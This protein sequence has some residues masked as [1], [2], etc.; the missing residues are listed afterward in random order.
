MLEKIRENIYKVNIRFSSS[1]MQEVNCYLFKGEQGYTVIDT[2]LYSKEA[3]EVWRRVLETGIVVEKVV[4]THTHQD[5]IGL[6][7]WFQDNVGVPVYT[8]NLGYKEMQKNRETNVR[9]KIKR[10]VVKHGGYELPTNSEDGSFIY[11]F[12]PDGFFEKNREI[13]LGD[14]LYEAIW[15]PGHAP[16]HFCFYNKSNKVMIVGD[17]LLKDISPVIGLWTGEEANPVEDY[18]HSLELIANCPTNIA[19]PGHGESIFELNK[20][21]AETKSRHASRLQQVLEGV[22]NERKTAHQVCEEIYGNLE[23]ALYVSQLMATITRLIYLESVG[24]VKRVEEEGIVMFQA[25]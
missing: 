16:D 23:S 11:D 14:E 4:L 24:K 19:L 1:G 22:E 17:H 8:S 9:D 12:E 21:V 7:K 2:G 25:I 5:H 6:A 10:L 15:T 3:F 13:L 20:R 18:Y